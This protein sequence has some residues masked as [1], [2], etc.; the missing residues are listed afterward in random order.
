MTQPVALADIQFNNPDPKQMLASMRRLVVELQKT[1]SALNSVVQEVTDAR[2][3][4]AAL[5]AA[6]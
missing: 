5:E 3:R 6:P 1:Q 2:A 4:I